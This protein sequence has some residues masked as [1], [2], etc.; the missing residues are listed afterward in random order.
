M[1]RKAKLKKSFKKPLK[2]V[3][4][5]TSNRKKV[6]KRGLLR[7]SQ[8]Y[9]QGLA[10]GREQGYSKGF[11]S[12]VANGRA[13]M[14]TPFEGTSIIIPTYNQKEMLQQCIE[15]IKAYTPEPHEIIVIDNGSDDGTGAYLDS[16]KGKVRYRI[17]GHNLGFAGGANQGLRMARGTT[18]LLLNN[19]TV[20]TSG[21]LSNMLRAVNESDHIGLAGPMTNYISGDQL[22][23]APYQNLMEM[24]HF[25]RSFNRSDSGKWSMTGRLTGFCF[26]MRRELFRRLGF[27]DE[28]FQVGN[29]EDDDFGLRVR[30]LGH[31]LYILGDTFIHHVGSVSMKALGT[32]DFSEVYG[33]NMQYY[34]R[35]WGLPDRLLGEVQGLPGRRKMTD[36][37]PAFGVVKGAGPQLYWIENG[38]RYPLDSA[39]PGLPVVRVSQIDLWSWP[40]G[41]SRSGASMG[42]WMVNL[43]ASGDE[44]AWLRGELRQS[45]DGDLYQWDGS[46]LRRLA[47]ETA[48]HTWGYAAF[49]SKPLT[50]EQLHEL[51][52]GPPIL[53]PIIL[54]AENL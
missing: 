45:P 54:A 41:E 48:L 17:N 13:T 30:L 31:E 29:C 35:K 50:T 43:H 24:Q 49:P 7:T 39:P 1:T 25:A 44:E 16:M 28:G 19:D 51:P 32:T 52:K 47:T 10:A 53:A 3:S 34:S 33:R 40:I 9:H 15:S 26:I 8:A 37:Y 23:S 46:A 11:E 20:V 14:L 36:F 27:F 2:R 22:V 21:W 5:R 42:A 6:V 4:K 12:G 18:L 38:V